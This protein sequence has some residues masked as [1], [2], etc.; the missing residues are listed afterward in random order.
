LLFIERYYQTLNAG[1]RVGIVIP[2]SVLDVE[3][4][5]VV[6]KFMIKYFHIRAVVSLPK[7][8]FTT[9]KISVLF[10][11]KREVPLE[12]ISLLS[13][14]L[15]WINKKEFEVYSSNLDGEQKKE[16]LSKLSI[17]TPTPP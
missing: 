2:E 8:T 11:E 1:G 10:L 13:K 5:D 17:L 7:Y 3:R 16:E 6:R 9:V 15:D 12:N 4:A 14:D